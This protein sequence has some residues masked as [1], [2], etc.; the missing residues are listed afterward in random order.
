M[1]FNEIRNAMLCINIYNPGFITFIMNMIIRRKTIVRQDN[2]GN[3][4]YE[5][6]EGA[7]CNIYPKLIIEELVGTSFIEVVKEAYL[8]YHIMILGIYN[9]EYSEIFVNPLN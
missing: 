1:S 7:K 9:N 3:W 4:F 6:L 8:C 5:Y 2:P